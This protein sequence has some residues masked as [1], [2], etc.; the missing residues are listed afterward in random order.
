MASG[1]KWGQTKRKAYLHFIN[2]II[3][4][5]IKI[6]FTSNQVPTTL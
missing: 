2:I 5:I 1:E 4:E 3:I 6:T